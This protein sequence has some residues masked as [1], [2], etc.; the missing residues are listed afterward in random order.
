MEHRDRPFPKACP[1]PRLQLPRA[2]IT[3]TV[4][5]IIK[6]VFA[7]PAMSSRRRRLPRGMPFMSNRIRS[8]QVTSGLARRKAFGLVDRNEGVGHAARPFAVL[9]LAASPKR[10]NSAMETGFVCGCHSGC[11]CTPSENG[12]ALRRADGF[13]QPILGESL[14][15]ERLWRVP[16]MPCQCNEFTMS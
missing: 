16:L 4:D 6:P 15:D 14:G 5:G 3:N 10:R 11:H 8:I 12:V 13:D 2:S 1:F 9:L 7:M